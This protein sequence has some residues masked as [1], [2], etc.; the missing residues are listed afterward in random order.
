MQYRLHAARV[1][2]H[3]RQACLVAT[4]R[5]TPSRS[6]VRDAA[7]SIFLRRSLRMLLPGEFGRCRKICAV[8]CAITPGPFA[9]KRICVLVQLHAQW[10]CAKFFH[11]LFFG[12]V[13]CFAMRRRASSTLELTPWRSAVR[14]PTSLPFPHCCNLA[15]A[16]S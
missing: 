2:I 8:L 14:V 9:W 3:Q 12:A 13:R 4:A 16:N 1:R 5:S 15:F 11:V 10:R 7:Q 6:P